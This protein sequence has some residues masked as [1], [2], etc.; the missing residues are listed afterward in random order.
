MAPDRS[1]LLELAAKYVWWTPPEDVLA[2]HLDRL[3]VGVM[4]M[5]TWED[6]NRLL[7]EIG[8]DAFRKVLE[9]PPAGAISAKSLAF[10]HYRLGLPGEPPKAGRRTFQ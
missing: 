2:N 4:E 5:G 9:A 10:W 8:E 3:T 6:A 7:A 1:T